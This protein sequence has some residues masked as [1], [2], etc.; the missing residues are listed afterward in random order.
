L[1]R[2]RANAATDEVGTGEEGKKEENLRTGGRSQAR[3]AG[4]IA[5]LYCFQKVFTTTGGKRKDLREHVVGGERG[6]CE[7]ADRCSVKKGEEI[8]AK[9]GSFTNR[10]PQKKVLHKK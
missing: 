10:R 9:G 7:E 8:F 6:N 1:H 5:A 2:I 3:K 4:K